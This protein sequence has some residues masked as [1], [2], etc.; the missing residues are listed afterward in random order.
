MGTI[1]A[2]VPTLIVAVVAFGLSPVEARAAGL[3]AAQSD[4]A[5]AAHVP[6]RDPNDYVK[7]CSALIA[8][9]KDTLDKC[10]G[11]ARVPDSARDRADPQGFCTAENLSRL[12]DQLAAAYNDRAYFLIQC[13]GSENYRRAVEDL[14]N[15]L[16]LLP[17]Y[18]IAIR[19]RA[20]AYMLLG[21]HADAKADFLRLID[22][23]KSGSSAVLIR[24]TGEAEVRLGLGFAELGLCE[25]APAQ[26]EFV[27]T[28]RLSL[29][30]IASDPWVRAAALFGQGL[31]LKVKG[32]AQE[33]IANTNNAV[34]AAERARLLRYAADLK[35]QGEARMQAARALVRAID[36]DVKDRFYIEEAVVIT[37]CRDNKLSA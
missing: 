15:A 32:A 30:P 22:Q 7:V 2:I 13:R 21:Q 35:G 20:I 9:L 25:V 34:T 23:M 26:E 16:K 24:P 36:A 5:C 14:D 33:R 18:A 11:V 17:N 31:G 6:G 28:E 1:R 10:A 12:G 19:N 4:S 8:Q 27:E 37:K 3:P 29:A